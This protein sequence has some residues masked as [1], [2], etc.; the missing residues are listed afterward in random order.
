MSDHGIDPSAIIYDQEIDPSVIVI[1]AADFDE[2][3][4]RMDDPPH[5]TPETKAANKL[6]AERLQEAN[7]AKQR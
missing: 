5:I 7:R 4:A 3:V 6:F 1:D 2:V